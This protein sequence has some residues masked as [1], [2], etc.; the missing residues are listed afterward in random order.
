MKILIFADMHGSLTALKKIKEKSKECEVI[1]CAGDLSVF[2]KNLDF[3]VDELSKT[4]KDVII[5]QG[6]HENEENMISICKRHENVHFIH[7]DKKNI[8]NFL[9]L[10]YGGGGFAIKDEEFEEVQKDMEKWIRAHKN[11]KII[12][13][14][15]GPPFG[16]KLDALGRRHVGNI[17]LREFIVKNRVDLLV[18]GHLHENKGKIDCIKDTRIINPGPYGKI[19]EFH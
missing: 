2:E 18:C 12:L 9:F 14:S 4:R 16:T 15:H 1:I 10:G 13:V 11:G 17:S 6:N 8:R 19:I 3:F 5:I 7:K